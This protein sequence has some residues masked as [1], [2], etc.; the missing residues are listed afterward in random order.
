[1]IQNAWPKGTNAERDVAS[2]L[3]ITVTADDVVEAQDRANA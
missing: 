2:F 1:L 3:S